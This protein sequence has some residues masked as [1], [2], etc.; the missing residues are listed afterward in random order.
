MAQ[1]EWSVMLGNKSTVNEH[2]LVLQV[3][4]GAGNAASNSTRVYFV[5]YV[6][7]TFGTPY[8]WSNTRYP[9]S[10]RIDKYSQSGS[11]SYDFNNYAQLVILNSYTDVVHN[12]DGTKRI[13]MSWSFSSDHIGSGTVNAALNLPTIPRAS[14]ATF[15]GT[16][17]AGSSVTINTNR[18]ASAFVH[19]LETFFGNDSDQWTSTAG[20]SYSWAV[21]MKYLNQIPTATNGI[22]QLRCH[23]WASQGGA[24][25]GYKN[26]GFTL[27]CPASVVPTMGNVTATEANSSVA[28]IVGAG[29]FVQNLS[30]VSY[31]IA[32]AAGAYASTIKTQTATVAG[33]TMT[34]ASG[35]TPKPINATGSQTVTYKVTDSRGR[36]ATKTNT[37]TVLAYANP[38][39]TSGSAV[40]ANASGTAVE[41]GTRIKVAVNA[42]VSSLVNGTEKN[43][44]TVRVFVRTK[45]ASSWGSAVYTGGSGLTFNTS[46]VLPATYS[47]LASYE[48]RV[49]VIDKFNTTVNQY[50]VPVGGVYMHWAENGI[51][52]G[53]YWE[54][55]ALD[56]L[57]HVYTTGNLS[58]GGT[59][60]AGSVPNARLTE[61]SYGL[62]TGGAT[63]IP[64]NNDA[65]QA[66]DTGFYQIKG[67]TANSPISGTW[68]NLIVQNGGSRSTQTATQMSA[69]HIEYK[70]WRNSGAWT[71]WV[72]VSDERSIVYL[73]RSTAAGTV[74]HGA[75]PAQGG[76]TVN[77]TLPAGGGR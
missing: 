15:A 7:R 64:P 11:T 38:V 68:F 30:K 20:A 40:R 6:E 36:T 51:G 4:L 73:P 10:I 23:T 46:T 54:R 22:G 26:T 42:R 41:D 48:V 29:R 14:T 60:I 28:S 45:G 65:N 74:A 70:R 16:V 71:A 69:T 19:T 9:W 43:A 35:T 58:I 75:A 33:Q 1:Y 32:G 12:S 72:P 77:I 67:D 2:R 59:M 5:A 63:Q 39:I 27:Y 44:I 18:A 37:I 50:T 25:I 52:V 24:Y 76:L 21:P 3:D 34:G 49:E 62:T 13:D 17:T 57:G 61:M 66:Y 8:S 47:L 53:K 56:V 55:G 31:S